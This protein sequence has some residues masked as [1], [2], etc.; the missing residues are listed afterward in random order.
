MGRCQLVCACRLRL[1]RR[2][3]KTRS[4][5]A[6]AWH[7]SVADVLSRNPVVHADGGVGPKFGGSRGPGRVAAAGQGVRNKANSSGATRG[8]SV[9]QSQFPHG[10]RWARAAKTA[11]G[12]RGPGLPNKANLPA[13]SSGGAGRHGLCQTKPIWASGRPDGSGTPIVCRPHPD[14]GRA[15]CSLDRDRAAAYNGGWNR[16]ESVRG[17]A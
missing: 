16:N 13:P 11:R 5:S 6:W 4:C 10:R 14:G 12:P 9:K 8:L 2:R 15:R 1:V 3:E 17:Y 7:P